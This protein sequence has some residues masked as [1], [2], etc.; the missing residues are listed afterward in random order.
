[1]RCLEKLH[2]LNDICSIRIDGQYFSPN[3]NLKFFDKNNICLIY[4]RNG[5][6]KSTIAKAFNY[7]KDEK[8]FFNSVK[9]YDDNDE[10]LFL[11]TEDKNKTL[12][13]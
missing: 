1:M 4:G 5:S 8:T 2:M 9:V 13:L 6:G 12:C 7:L 10:E 3:F 11:S